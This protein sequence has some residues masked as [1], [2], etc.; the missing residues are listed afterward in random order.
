MHQAA[1]N[2]TI[3]SIRGLLK[4]HAE[5]Q[6]SEIRVLQMDSAEIVVAVL[7]CFAENREE[8]WVGSCFVTSHLAESA[9][10]ATLDALNRRIFYLI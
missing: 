7:K 4:Q 1:A 10:R 2:A 9:V 8:N 5:I 3:N 6:L